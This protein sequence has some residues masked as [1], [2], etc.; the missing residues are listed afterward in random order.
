MSAIT[1]PRNWLLLASV[2]FA[3]LQTI[4]IQRN[5]QLIWDEAVYMQ[6]GRYIATL[7]EAGFWEILRPPALPTILSAVETVSNALITSPYVILVIA[8]TGA[9]I[10]YKLL[11]E[12]V[13][14]WVASATAILLLFFSLYFQYASK[15]LTNLPAATL[16]L[17]AAYTHHKNKHAWTGVLLAIAFL[18]RFPAG[19][20]LAAF[21]LVY[22]YRALADYKQGWLNEHTKALLAYTTP[23]LAIILVW[24]T[25]NYFAWSQETAVWWHA[26]LR[27][28]LYGAS[29]VFSQNLALY[30]HSYAYYFVRFLAQL[31]IILLIIPGITLL[32]KRQS[33][34]A[35]ALTSLFVLLFISW[36][37]NQQWRFALLSLPG[38]FLLIGIGADYTSK[39]NFL[40]AK[41]IVSV[42]FIASISISGLAMG[43]YA[44][45]YTSDNPQLQE[46]Y[47][48]IQENPVRGTIIVNDPV[49][50]AYA[51]HNRVRPIYFET[52]PRF[53]DALRE[54]H[55]MVVFIPDNFPCY[56]EQ[57]V[58]EQEL[59]YVI[60]SLTSNQKLVYQ[61]TILGKEHYIFSDQTWFIGQDT[62]NLRAE[63]GLG[64]KVSLSQHPFDEFPVA[65]VLE[66]FPSL[67][68]T[69]DGIWKEEIFYEVLNITRNYPATASIIPEH[70][71]VFNEIEPELVQAIEQEFAIA[72]NGDNHTDLPGTNQYERIREGMQTITDIFGYRSPVFIPPQYNANQQTAK[73]LQELQFEVYISTVGDATQLNITR[74]DQTTSI[75]TNWERNEHK[76]PQEIMREIR[77][78]Q[79][80]ERYGLVNIFYFMTENSTQLNETLTL[81]NNNT[82]LLEVEELA[83]WLENREQTTLSIQANTITVTGPQEAKGTTLLARESGNY[84]VQSNIPL[85][86]KNAHTEDIQICIETV[87]EQLAPNQF[88]LSKS[89]MVIPP[90]DGFER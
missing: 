47:D 52:L 1:H 56:Q 88:F 76:T 83:Q 75:I 23:A 82:Q 81:L 15:V 17:A 71:S 11:S 22:L 29:N 55:D 28:I 43:V 38:I 60:D 70:I 53:R 85:H 27:P 25:I 5:T 3:S 48:F 63:Y 89:A 20:A 30:D 86:L 51:H 32:K 40:R 33:L 12:Y 49:F 41:S 46:A 26:A 14:D 57:Q 21:G 9:W 69:R 39:M 84:S 13:D 37:T 10:L 74:L 87:C 42:L 90:P 64:S 18:T 19:L 59:T 72:Q 80:Y 36:I 50:G 62:A 65:L 31:P 7:G 61:N 34:I 8:I 35:P 66:D 79:N 4:L 54:D 24:M 45:E 6:M 67:N 73:A 58:C 2:L 78:L 68:D 44:F 16:I 77:T